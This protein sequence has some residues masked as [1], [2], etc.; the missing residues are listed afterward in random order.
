[1]PQVYRLT[2]VADDP[3]RRR[4]LHRRL[5]V[6]VA[7]ASESLATDRIALIRDRPRFD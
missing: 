3:P 5:V 6:D 7:I 2:P 1:V 4:I